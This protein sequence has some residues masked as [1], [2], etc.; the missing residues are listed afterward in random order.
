M[1]TVS[2]T[3]GAILLA[4]SLSG[5]SI[6]SGSDDEPS[7]Q[8]DPRYQL[9][10]MITKQLPKELRRQGGLNAFVEKAA[11]IDQGAGIQFDCQARIS[12]SGPNGGLKTETLP[13][14]GTCD[15]RTCAWRTDP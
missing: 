4:F 1:R 9:E 13:I 10:T 11:C 3:L 5:C 7:G 14:H 12:Y 8:A 6:N 15:E 2:L